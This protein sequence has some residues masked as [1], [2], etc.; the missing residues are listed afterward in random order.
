[1]ITIFPSGS[2]TSKGVPSGSAVFLQLLVGELGTPNLPK[3]SPMANGYT[4]TEFYYTARRIWTTD[5]WKCAI[6]RTD[7]LSHQISSTLPPKLPPKPHFGG[8]FSANPITERA[9]RK[10]HVNGATKLKR[11]SYIGIGKHFRMCQN[12]AAKGGPG[13]QCPPPQCKFGTPPIISESTRARKLNLKIPLDK[14]PVLGTKIITLQH[15]GG[16]HIDF[17]EMSISPGQTTANNCKTAFS[18]HVV[19]NASDDYNF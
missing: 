12:F 13:A 16:R 5:V 6:L 8:P 17:R 1:M 11:F 15:E 7:V 10:S 4:S 2:R 18:L 3:R 14:V 9:L 19:E